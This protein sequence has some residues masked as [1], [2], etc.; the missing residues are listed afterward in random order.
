[1]A[2]G[3]V[4]GSLMILIAWI[5]RFLGHSRAAR[6]A[7]A[8]G[9]LRAVGGARFEVHQGL[10]GGVRVADDGRGPEGRERFP[11]CGVARCG[12]HRAQ[13]R[14]SSQGRDAVAVRRSHVDRRGR[15]G[16][17]EGPHVPDRG[18]RPRT[19]PGDMGAR[20]GRQGRVRPVLRGPHARTARLRRGRRR[21]RGP[22]G[23]AC[24]SGART[25]SACP[26]GSASSHG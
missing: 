14:R 20:R 7:R 12:R 3:E 1:M 2:S 17:R 19:G 26:T 8:R 24:A 6:S 13:G 23:H 25:P 11:A 9:R 5:H 22:V 16:L 15:D 21:R 10:R 18:R 4:H